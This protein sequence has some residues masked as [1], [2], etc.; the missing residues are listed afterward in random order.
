M[1]KTNKKSAKTS[2][3]EPR[4]GHCMEVTFEQEDGRTETLRLVV[5]RCGVAVRE[6]EALRLFVTEAL[7]A[8]EQTLGR[9][10]PADLR[11][12]LA[13]HD[14]GGHFESY[15]HLGSAAKPYAAEAT[16]RRH[17]ARPFTEPESAGALSSAPRRAPRGA[18]IDRLHRQLERRARG[19]ALQSRPLFEALR[20]AVERHANGPP[21]RR[22]RRALGMRHTPECRVVERC[23]RRGSRTSA[24]EYE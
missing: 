22:A 9:A 4:D 5:P 18:P 11:A 3:A 2:A 21:R 14:G 1:T 10:L 12:S 16:A 8:L 13:I 19:Q 17:A 23:S 15:E 20:P 7:A 24:D 6:A